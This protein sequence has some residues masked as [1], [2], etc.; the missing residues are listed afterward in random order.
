[1]PFTRDIRCPFINIEFNTNWIL[2]LVEG[3]EYKF[4]GSEKDLDIYVGELENDFMIAYINNTKLSVNDWLCDNY[5]N[6]PH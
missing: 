4:I 2:E 5:N 1:M 6:V 3:F